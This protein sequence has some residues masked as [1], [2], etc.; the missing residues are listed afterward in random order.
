MKPASGFPE[1]SLW[2]SENPLRT[3][4]KTITFVVIKDPMS[5]RYFLIILLLLPCSLLGQ[6]VLQPSA[7]KEPLR[8]FLDANAGWSLPLGSYAATD[9]EQDYTG[10]ATSG[11][12]VQLGADWMGKKDFGILFQYVYQN[13]PLNS[14]AD[15]VTPAGT[16]YPLGGSGWSNNYLM[17]G[18]L[19]FKEIKKLSVDA[20]VVVGI[21][22]ASSPVF[23]NMDPVTK[24]NTKNTATGFAYGIGIGLGYMISPRF[25]V[26]ISVSLLN[27]TPTVTRQYPS[28][29][30]GYDSIGVPIYSAPVEVQIKKKVST[31]HTGIGIIYKF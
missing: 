20:R 10:Y 30:I 26:K 12:F 2:I 25:T 16:I 8:L 18:P 9:P 1:C 21:M 19:F 4:M 14:A 29:V 23:S 15:S 22:F 31:L 24:E 17:V 11:Y 7:K 27:A 13:N 3:W 5:N 6:E 28:S